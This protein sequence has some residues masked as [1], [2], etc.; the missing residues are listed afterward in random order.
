MV[1]K[2]TPFSLPLFHP[3]EKGWGEEA[4]LFLC[5]TSLRFLRHQ[6]S[7]ARNRFRNFV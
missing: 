1:D 4:R 7:V 3:M 2:P 6:R 5:L